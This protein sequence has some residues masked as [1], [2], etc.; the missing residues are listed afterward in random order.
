METSSSADVST[1]TNYGAVF[2]AT[3]TTMIYSQYFDVENWNSLF[4]R[5][6]ITP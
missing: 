2:T 4:F 6:Q 1:W 5:L 3:N